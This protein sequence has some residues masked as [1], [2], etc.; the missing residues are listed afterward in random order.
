MLEDGVP[1]CARRRQ[2]SHS[3][4]APSTSSGVT[5]LGDAYVH[6][7]D[8][9]D[10]I[11]AGFTIAEDAQDG[12]I[13]FSAVGAGS[14]VASAVPLRLA[15]AGC[16][17]LFTSTSFG[18]P[19]YGQLLET[20]D[21]AIASGAAAVTITAGADTG[22]EMG[23]F[24]SELAPIKENGLLIKYAEYMPLGLTPVVVHVT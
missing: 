6:R 7:L 17:A 5:V 2:R 12:C 23:A 13:R 9:S 18:E 11:L 19:A 4:Q 3:A 1:G 14:R 8:A 20:A 21:R 22:S 15:C 24:S 16:A 10:S